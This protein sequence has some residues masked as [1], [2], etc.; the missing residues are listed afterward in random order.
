MRIT[1]LTLICFAAFV[2]ASFA[3]A[4]NLSGNAILGPAQS[5]GYGMTSGQQAVP[6]ELNDGADTFLAFRSMNSNYCWNTDG[7]SDDYFVTSLDSS[8]YFNTDQ[9]TAITNLIAH[10]YATAFSP[11]GGYSY[12]DA[13]LIQAAIWN[14]V[15]DPGSN[16][17]SGAGHYLYNADGKAIGLNGEEI[18]GSE[19][20]IAINNGNL[21]WAGSYV[22][23]PFHHTSDMY[24][25][26]VFTELKKNDYDILV[27]QLADESNS[28]SPE[29]FIR[30]VSKDGDINESENGGNATPEPATLAILGLGLVGLP[31]SRRF[32]KKN[33]QAS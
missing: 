3:D 1:F 19:N 24:A 30:V 15:Y 33:T 7:S 23:D 14:I 16:G 26:G 22:A 12:D 29:W 25:N 13:A 18:S 11:N 2:S 28:S 17:F 9:V 20:W 21:S 6:Y 32:R 10:T 27:Y 31:F 8:K 5:G 4:V